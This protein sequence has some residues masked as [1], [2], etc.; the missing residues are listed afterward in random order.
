MWV[1]ESRWPGCRNRAVWVHIAAESSSETTKETTR[2][3]DRGDVPEAS[4]RFVT[5]CGSTKEVQLKSHCR[6]LR[7]KQSRP[8]PLR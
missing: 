7:L 5:R 6:L 4:R 1:S 8:G 2:A 3:H